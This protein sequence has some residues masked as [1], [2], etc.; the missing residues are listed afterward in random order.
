[1]S[2]S[3]YIH[4]PQCRL[5]HTKARNE[6]AI[7]V[8]IPSSL[9]AVGAFMLFLLCPV[10]LPSDGRPLSTSLR[11]RFSPFWTF[12]S[13]PFLVPTPT[14]TPGSCRYSAYGKLRYGTGGYTAVYAFSL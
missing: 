12:I 14:L 5:G 1:M 9:R 13:L 3:A 11:V 4:P 6:L 10:H 2:C 8:R 7:C